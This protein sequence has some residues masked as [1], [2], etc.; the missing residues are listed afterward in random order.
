MFSFS[1]F[2]KSSYFFYLLI[3]SATIFIVDTSIAY[4]ADFLVEFNSSLSGIILFISL[5]IISTIAN[6]VVI[7]YI[8]NRTDSVR[9]KSKSVKILH[10]A[11]RIVQYV[12]LVNIG[13]VTMWILLFSQY[14]TDSLSLTTFI[15]NSASALLLGWF[16]YRFMLWFLSNKKSVVMLLYA[17]SF[18]ILSFSE[19]M[20]AVGDTYLLIEK[21]D[22]ISPDSEVTFY[23]F[24]EGT[25]FATFYDYY[26]YIDISAFLL[27]LGA[28]SILLY[29]YSTKI[30]GIKLI[31]IIGL[32]LLSYISGYLDT[33]NIYD[34]DTNPDLFSYYVFQS[35]STM[36]AGILFA[37]SVWIVVRN[38]S[39]TTI[40][41]F[42]I[43][44]AY[45]F[46]LFY[47]TNSASVTVTPYAPFGL[48][49]LSFL[50][51]ATYLILIGIYSSAFS[52]SQNISLRASIRNLA[53]QNSNLLHNIGTSQMDVQLKNIMAKFKDKILQEESNMKEQTGISANM[54]ADEMEDY[55]KHVIK[56]LVENRERR[57]SRD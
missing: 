32:P 17:L 15:S 50:P 45:G 49:S 52:L 35:L 14:F 40:K 9:A 28:T 2:E 36:S 44:T 37:I 27:M 53:S 4:V 55:V 21:D 29:S 41:N 43:T 39:D 54:E 56:E 5:V 57:Q 13:L 11:V 23:D 42:M 34:T 1:I 31:I 10:L 25:F 30:R 26:D 16:A 7:K 18:L 51:L 24:E 38:M 6:F 22:I 47:I 3:L 48:I 46:I 8:E 19:S 12:L 33:L 20:V